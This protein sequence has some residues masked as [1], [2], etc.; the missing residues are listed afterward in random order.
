MHTSKE[1]HR[2][3]PLGAHCV[4]GKT[5]HAAGRGLQALQRGCPSSSAPHRARLWAARQH[6]PVRFS[7][8]FGWPIFT[9]PLIALLTW[10]IPCNTPLL[11]SLFLLAVLTR[12]LSCAYL[13][14]SIARQDALPYPLCH[15]MVLFLLLTLL[16]C[17]IHLHTRRNISASLRHPCPC[18]GSDR[19]MQ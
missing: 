7:D 12:S 3:Q 4:Q 10:H 18:N 15:S 14:L 5:Q 2:E 8:T 19:M 11:L 6:S 17:C 13:P 1:H 16:L 9:C